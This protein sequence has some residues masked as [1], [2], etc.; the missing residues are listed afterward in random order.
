ML[1]NRI[2]NIYTANSNHFEHFDS[3]TIINPMSQ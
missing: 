3:I 1:D 2:H